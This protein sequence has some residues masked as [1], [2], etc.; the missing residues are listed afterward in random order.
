LSLE[1][2]FVSVPVSKGGDPKGTRLRAIFTAE[3]AS[4]RA[5]GLRGVL[6]GL[7]AILGIPLWVALIWP[8]SISRDVR[9]LTEA[10][11]AM[12]CA[13]VLLAAVWEGWWRR[14]RSRRIA[15]LGPL[16]VLRSPPL[17]QQACASLADEED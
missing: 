3:S 17:E 4:V 5:R 13:G 12:A 14:Q 11:W 6:I 10:L 1:E 16:P 2:S 15:N 9:A 7:L 8:A